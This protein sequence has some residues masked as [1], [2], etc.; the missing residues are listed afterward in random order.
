MHKLSNYY[1]NNKK[2]AKIIAMHGTH[3]LTLTCYRYNIELSKR[4]EVFLN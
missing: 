1:V 4:C 3:S 2:Y